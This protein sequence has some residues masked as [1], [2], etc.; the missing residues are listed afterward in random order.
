MKSPPLLFPLLLLLLLELAVPV[1]D[2]DPVLPP[3]PQ[4]T[5][6]LLQVDV[7]V[8]VGEL[9]VVGVPDGVTVGLADWVIVTDGVGDGAPDSFWTLP[10]F[11]AAGKGTSDAF[12]MMVCM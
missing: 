2:A 8:G 11:V 7:A 12:F 3:F 4:V 1:G 9:D 10:I 6:H 5:S